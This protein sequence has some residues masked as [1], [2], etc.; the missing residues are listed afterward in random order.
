MV[1]AAL[2]KH[3]RNLGVLTEE[4]EVRVLHGLAGVNSQILAQHDS[5]PFV[6]RERLGHIAAGCQRP[7]QKQ[8]PRLSERGHVDKFAGC[9]FRARQLGAPKF[10]TGFRV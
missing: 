1:V 3:W 2:A 10:Q 8:M 7:H 9:T 5:E 6:R 4:A